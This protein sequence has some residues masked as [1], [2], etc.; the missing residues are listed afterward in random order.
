MK[1]GKSPVAHA[2]AARRA[3]GCGVL[4]R[5]ALDFLL[6]ETVTFLLAAGLSRESLAKQLRMEVG[7][8]SAA[9]LSKRSRTA[10]VIKREHESTMEIRGVVHDWHRQ[11]R[12]TDKKTGEPL[13]L[14][15][16]VLRQL[17]GKR[18]PASRIEDT[19]RWMEA[20]GTVHRRKDGRFAL[21]IG[22]AVLVGQRALIMA[23]A[24]V[25]VPQYLRIALRNARARDSR[26]RDVDRD[27]RVFFLPEKYVRL[28]RAVARERSQAFLEGLDNWLEDH[29]RADDAGPTVEAA[30]HCYCY[31]GEPRSLRRAATNIGRLEAQH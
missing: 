6:S 5:S 16:A 1:A 3:R 20:N 26:S 18:F 8:V 14:R 27:A 15:G 7:R 22:R 2:L 30:V 23:R 28:W 25:V 12:Y 24:A 21:S 29:T 4:S 9:S 19:L 13:A 31:T 10:R 11:R 17:I